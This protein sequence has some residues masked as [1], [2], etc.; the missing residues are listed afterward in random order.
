VQIGNRADL[1]LYAGV[2]AAAHQR[3]KLERLCC[4]I[5]RLAALRP[6]PRVHLTRYHGV[7]VPHSSLRSQVTPAG[8]GQTTRA[9]E[10]SPA[11]RHRAMTCRDARM[12]RAQGCARAAELGQAAEAGVSHRDRAVRAL[13]GEGADHCQY[14]GSAGD[15]EEAPLRLGIPIDVVE[16]WFPKV[17]PAT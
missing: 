13:R 2:S 3:D 5:A 16:S 11:E 17:Y 14:R 15:R 12:S 9:T 4:Y 8:R 1:S 10:R 6:K 7:S